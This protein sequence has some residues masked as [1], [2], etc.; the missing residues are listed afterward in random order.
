MNSRASE[1]ERRGE[2]EQPPL[3]QNTAVASYRSPME[4]INFKAR[5]EETRE[6]NNYYCAVITSNNKAVV[7]EC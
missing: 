5:V 2:G 7:N 4:L 6:N 3:L 1:G